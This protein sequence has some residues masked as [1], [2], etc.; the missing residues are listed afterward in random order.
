MLHELYSLGEV[1]YA[2]FDEETTYKKV[3]AGYRLDRP[4]LCP[5]SVYAVMRRCWHEVAEQRPSFTEL[6]DQLESI[7]PADAPVVGAT[8]A[9][10]A[11]PGSAGS[12]GSGKDEK[13]VATYI[14]YARSE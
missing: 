14:A 5:D 11:A 12:G 7:T 2:F 4:D 13:P 9:P 3:K 1:P 10:A 8:Q 6:F